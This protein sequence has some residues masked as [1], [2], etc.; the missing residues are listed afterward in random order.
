MADAGGPGRRPCRRWT[1]ERIV[2]ARAATMTLASV[3]LAL[4]VRPWF[5]LLTAF[6]GVSQWTYVVLSDYPASLALH[7]CGLAEAS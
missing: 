5:A 4:L 2:F 1:L 6:A 7:R 3:T